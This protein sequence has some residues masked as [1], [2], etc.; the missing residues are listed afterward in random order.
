M[1]KPRILVTGATGKTGSVVVGELLK[2]G[3]PIRALV[4]WRSLL[5]RRSQAGRLR[6][7]CAHH[8]RARCD[9][10]PAE[11]FETI[12]RRHA[13]LSRNQ[14]TFGNWLREFAQF[15]IAPLGPGFNLDR[16]D[17]DLRSPFPSEP[18][19]V[20]ESKVWRREHA[21]AHAERGALNPQLRTRR[22]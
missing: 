20:L 10:S 22:A 9:R 13:A 19:F 11:D 2:A 14:R 18:Q 8:G 4:Q 15:V 7:G 5:H 1:L 16:Y 12:A 3:Y 17:R 6:P 21:I